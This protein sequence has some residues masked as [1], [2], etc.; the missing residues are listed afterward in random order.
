MYERDTSKAKF[1][2]ISRHVSPA[3]LPDISAYYHEA[4]VIYSGNDW[5][6]DGYHTTG[7]KWSQCLGHAVINHPVKVTVY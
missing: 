4:L 7:Q 1:T 2:A 5:N 3:S 6:S